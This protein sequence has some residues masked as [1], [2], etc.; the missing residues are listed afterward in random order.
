MLPEIQLNLLTFK[1]K[2]VLA[3][4]DLMANVLLCQLYWLNSIHECYLENTKESNTW[5][6]LICEILMDKGGEWHVK[7][8]LA[9]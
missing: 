9:F 6:N 4:L 3:S 8:V 1:R 5:F 7:C 2:Q